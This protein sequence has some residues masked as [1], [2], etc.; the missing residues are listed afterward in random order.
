M[1]LQYQLFESETQKQL[2]LK[3]QNKNMFGAIDKRIYIR[4]I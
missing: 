1:L 2:S 3:K 4:L